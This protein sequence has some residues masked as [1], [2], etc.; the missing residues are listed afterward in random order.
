MIDTQKAE[1]LVE[2]WRR[3][4]AEFAKS[5]DDYMQGFGAGLSFAATLLGLCAGL[6]LAEISALESL[7][8]DLRGGPA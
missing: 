7:L 2:L 5:D 3:Q 1:M 6:R 4:S 8:K